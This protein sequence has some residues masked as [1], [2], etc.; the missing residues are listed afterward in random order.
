MLII[1][2][3]FS[4]FNTNEEQQYIDIKKPVVVD[5]NSYVEKIVGFN[6]FSWKQDKL[7]FKLTGAV[8][9]SFDSQPNFIKRPVIVSYVKEKKQWQINAKEA[10]QYKNNKIKFVK[11]VIVKSLVKSQIIKTEELV[12]DNKTQIVSSDKKVIFN[13]DNLSVVAN[14]IQLN[15][16]KQIIQLSKGV[17]AKYE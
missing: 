3:V 17:R 9:Y 7:K 5:I 12:F 4:K 13:S 8:F 11:K 2:L 14:N 6:F 16:T 1:I 15:L 10:Y